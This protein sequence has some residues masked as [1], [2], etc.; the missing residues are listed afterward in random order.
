MESHRIKIGKN[1]NASGNSASAKNK[2]VAA[3][4][5]VINKEATSKADDK[6]GFIR[7]FGRPGG[8]SRCLLL[9]V[10]IAFSCKPIYNR[11]VHSA[12]FCSYEIEHKG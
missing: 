9:R 1:R 4:K 6:S 7:V 10:P 2:A 8:N 3:N 11:P 5:A 12:R